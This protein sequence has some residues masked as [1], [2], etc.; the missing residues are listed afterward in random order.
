MKISFH[1]LPPPCLRGASKDVLRQEA[2][3]RA[4]GWE[5]VDPASL[6]G[7]GYIA[8]EFFWSNIIWKN[9]R[10]LEEDFKEAHWLV[11]DVDDPEAPPLEYAVKTWCEH[12]SF[13]GLSKSHQT[14]KHGVKCDRYRVA[15]LLDRPITDFKT[16][17][18]NTKLLIDEYC[19]DPSCNDGSQIYFPCKSVPYYGTG[20]YRLKVL[21]A[22]KDYVV[23]QKTSSSL[24]FSPK[25]CPGYLPRWITNQIVDGLPQ[26]SI[27]SGVYKLTCTLRDYGLDKNHIYS[28]LSQGN[29]KLSSPSE[30]EE[31]I[32]AGFKYA[33]NKQIGKVNRER[34]RL[35]GEEG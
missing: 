17:H 2:V 30:W 6:Y 20:D 32:D 5:V 16:F 26:G 35:P 34:D 24:V 25:K 19:G 13:I 33:R 21:D 8:E 3:K 23:K 12:A 9:D 31:V 11:L 28:I 10:H 4:S 1:P 7:A 22:P 18:Y 15:L 29:I 14:E 27:R